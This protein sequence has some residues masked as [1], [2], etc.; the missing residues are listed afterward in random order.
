VLATWVYV[1]RRFEQ[2]RG[3]QIKTYGDLIRQHRDEHAVDWLTGALEI[4]A[5]S[6][7]FN[8]SCNI[9][10]AWSHSPH[11]RDSVLAALCAR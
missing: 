8:K 5:K 2:E 1:E 4:T 9:C 6:A 7:M 11:R 10:C 3:T